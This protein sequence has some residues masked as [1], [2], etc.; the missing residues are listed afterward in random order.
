[1]ITPPR[2]PWFDNSCASLKGDIGSLG[3]KIKNNSENQNLK[4]EL[5]NLKRKLKKLVHKN[6]HA[7]KGNSLQEINMHTKVIYS[8]K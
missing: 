5:S 4:I 2:P 3:R 8:K 6:K 1:M 7:Y